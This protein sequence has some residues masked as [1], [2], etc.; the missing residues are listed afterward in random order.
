[1][2]SLIL[3]A[4]FAVCFNNVLS[5]DFTCG[6][7][8][9][10]FCKA[11]PSKNS[12]IDVSK[13]CNA[14][15]G[16]YKHSELY[17]QRYANDFIIKSYDYL[18]LASNFGTY[19]KN[20]PGFEKIF[21]GLADK[22]WGNARDLIEFMTKR[23][24]RHTFKEFDKTIVPMTYRLNEIEA[25]GKALDIEKSLAKQSHDIHRFISHANNH[26]KYDPAVAH[27]LDEH[28]H[29]YQTETIRALSGHVN[30]LHKLAKLNDNK[31]L[32]LSIQLFD[33]YLQK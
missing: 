21:R 10:G 25:M 11:M 7:I 24:G 9:D 16:A 15:Y 19:A 32:A 6:T 3:L 28:F 17:L 23:G 2:K 8:G 13:C 5:E 22:A 31:L 20:R 18:F 4:V 14:T 12:C 26:T 33:E 27:Y 30:D 1:M 29:E